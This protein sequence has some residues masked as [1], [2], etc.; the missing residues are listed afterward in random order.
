LVNKLDKM[1][2]ELAALRAEMAKNQ[3]K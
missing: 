1:S 3:V 2:L